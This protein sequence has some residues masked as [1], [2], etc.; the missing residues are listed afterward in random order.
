MQDRQHSQQPGTPQEPK[1]ASLVLRAIAILLDSAII[2]VVAIIVVGPDN[3]NH[4]AGLAAYLGGWA[5]YYIGFTVVAGATP[6]KMAVGIH[7]AGKD[8]GRPQPDSVILRYVIMMAGAL[9]FGIGTIISMLMVISDPRRRALHDRIAGTL[10]LDGRPPLE[11]WR[12][13]SER[14]GDFR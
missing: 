5:L 11:E 1:P 12:R 14:R 7:V 6:G 9:P 10:V 13:Q 3:L 4:G 2:F 8:G